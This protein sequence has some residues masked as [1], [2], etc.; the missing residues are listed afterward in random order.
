MPEEEK[1]KLIDLLGKLV[2][3]RSVSAESDI[4]RGLNGLYRK[5]H[6]ECRAE[7]L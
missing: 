6:A 2:S 4:Q 5:F 7:S 3:F 1:N